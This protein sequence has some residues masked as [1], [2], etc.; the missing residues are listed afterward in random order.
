MIL[1]NAIPRLKEKIEEATKSDTTQDVSFIYNET[2]TSDTIGSVFY[3]LFQQG[4]EFKTRYDEY[5][6]VIVIYPK[7]E[8]NGN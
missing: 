4:I 8:V 2:L 6:F 7:Q 3:W 1:N 5:R